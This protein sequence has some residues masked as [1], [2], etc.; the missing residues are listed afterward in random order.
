LI[1]YIGQEE[2]KEIKEEKGNAS[3]GRLLASPEEW[4]GREAALVEM[5]QTKG[6]S[7][8]MEPKKEQGKGRRSR[9]ET[10]HEEKQAVEAHKEHPAQLLLHIKIARSTR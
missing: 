5:C 1:I 8:K 9:M 7:M 2:Y 3:E 10:A 4:G 6:Q